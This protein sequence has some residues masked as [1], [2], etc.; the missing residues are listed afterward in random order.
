MTDYGNSTA[1]VTARELCLVLDRPSRDRR[2]FFLG[3]NLPSTVVLSALTGEITGGS[4]L[5]V[6]RALDIIVSDYCSTPQG[7]PE[8]SAVL[9]EGTHMCRAIAFHLTPAHSTFSLASWL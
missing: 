5:N 7:H 9:A 1:Q 6:A 2:E 3:L 8:I 4:P